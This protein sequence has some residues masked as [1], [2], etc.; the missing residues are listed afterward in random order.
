MPRRTLTPEVRIYTGRKQ[1]T[2]SAMS[3][4]PL[5]GV[6]LFRLWLVTAIVARSGYR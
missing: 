5:I 3:G 1:N 4:L 6:V 2:P